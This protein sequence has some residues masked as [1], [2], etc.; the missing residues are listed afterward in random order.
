MPRLNNEP[1]H[2]PLI[3]GASLGP[4]ARTHCVMRIELRA[5]PCNGKRL[6]KHVARHLANQHKVA[7][8][9]FIA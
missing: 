9:C 5:L 7:V 8:H 4:V 3:A 2:D 6:V 1:V